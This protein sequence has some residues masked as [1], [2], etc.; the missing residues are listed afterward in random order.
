[1]SPLTLLAAVATAICAGALMWVLVPPTPRLASR[2]RPYISPSSPR[3]ATPSRSAVRRVFGPILMRAANALSRRLDAAGEE[4][5]ALRLRRSGLYPDLGDEERVAVFRLRQLRSLAFG[6]FAF[7][8]VGA[9]VDLSTGGVVGLGMVGAVAAVGRTRGRVERA[10][11]ERTTRMR[12]EIYTIDQLLAL[13]VRAGG[14]VMQAVM[15]VVE[16]GRGE[17]VAEL[18]EAV[19]MHRAGLSVGESFRRVADLSP[20][21]ACARTYRLLGIADERGV[22]LAAGLLALAEDVRETRREA[23]KRAA[24]RRRAAMLVPTIA[25]LAPTLLLFVAAPLP[26][27]L[28]GWR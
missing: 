26:Y 16:R 25:L 5:L 21:P 27:L 11:E 20:E 15:Q 28:T 10:M 3:S 14:A 6:G 13:R 1:M 12:I 9:A 2:V 7:G 19:R 23:M 4:A 8:L 18:A 24:T 17:V 22:D